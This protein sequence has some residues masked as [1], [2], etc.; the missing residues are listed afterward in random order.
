MTSPIS[1][2][3]DDELAQKARVIAQ[4]ENRS[5]SNVIVNAVAVFTDL[6]R[7]L[8]DALIELRAEGEAD[9]YREM[10]REMMAFIARRRLDRA[11][12]RLAAEGRFDSSLGDASDLELLEAATAMSSPP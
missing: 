3:L 9:T 1:A 2:N 5:L 6:P 11:V 10:S 4:K 7:E 8:R 12:R